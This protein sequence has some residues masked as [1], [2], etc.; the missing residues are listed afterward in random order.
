MLHGCVVIQVSPYPFSE[1][2]GVKPRGPHW[3][4]RTHPGPEVGLEDTAVRQA[5]RVAS[6]PGAWVEC[7]GSYAGLAVN[8]REFK[9]KNLAHV[10]RQFCQHLHLPGGSSGEAAP[11]SFPSLPCAFRKQEDHHPISVS[12]LQSGRGNGSGWVRDLYRKAITNKSRGV[13]ECPNHHRESPRRLRQRKAWLINGE[14]NG[15]WRTLW[16][17]D[18]ADASCTPA[19]PLNGG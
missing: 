9:N 3:S 14:G 7:H 1:A 4:R 13:L 5:L 12:H 8:P 18:Q 2:L 19:Q 10:E 11:R 16:S 17:K 15:G 6:A